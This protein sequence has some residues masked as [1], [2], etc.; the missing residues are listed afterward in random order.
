MK[1]ITNQSPSFADSFI[2]IPES[3]LD[4]ISLILDRVRFGNAFA[5]I[6]T[7]YPPEA[8]FRALLLRELYSISYDRLSKSLHRDLVFMGF[9]GF[10]V[11]GEKPDEST[12][13]RFRDR[14]IG[15][16]L[17]ETLLDRLNGVLERDG[18]KLSGG[19]AVADATLV[20]SA[21]RPRKVFR[22]EGDGSVSG[23]VYSD[24][25]DATWKTKGKTSRYGYAV[26][27]TT[28]AD[29]L[30]TAVAVAPANESEMTA[31]P[32]KVADRVAKGRRIVYDKGADSAANR[33]ACRERG[34][35]DGIM[36]RKPK[37]REMPHW[38]KVRNRLLSKLRFV[39]ERT[40]GTMKR[41]YGMSRARLVGL[42]K[43]ETGA[44]AKSLAY[45]LRRAANRIVPACGLGRLPL[46]V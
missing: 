2:D 30:V 20:P 14:L 43:V 27:A 34:L 42:A 9:C 24:D 39:V 5:D 44:I 10:S 7:D 16:G 45:N 12:L 46:P 28:D 21:R 18:L 40:F 38:E 3:D 6:Q 33:N 37:G 17:W 41:T 36:R 22:A 29:G 8:L 31:F 11:S 15:K 23:P 32:E 26:T 35:K 1:I 19:V 13:I 25:P 4:G